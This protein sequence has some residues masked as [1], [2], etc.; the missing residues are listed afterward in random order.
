LDSENRGIARAHISDGIGRIVVFW[1][2]GMSKR[3]QWKATC[4]HTNPTKNG[5]SS[6]STNWMGAAMMSERIWATRHSLMMTRSCSMAPVT[7]QQALYGLDMV[8]IVFTLSSISSHQSWIVQ[9]GFYRYCGTKVW[10][11]NESHASQSIYSVSL[12]NRPGDFFISSSGF[13]EL[14]NDHFSLSPIV[15]I[16]IGDS[17]PS[18]LQDF[19]NHFTTTVT[20][21]INWFSSRPIHGGKL[22]DAMWSSVSQKVYL[23]QAKPIA[24][25][26]PIQVWGRRASQFWHME[27]VLLLVIESP[28]RLWWREWV[29]YYRHNH[30]SSQHF[31]RETSPKQILVKGWERWKILLV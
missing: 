27:H 17:H 23:F 3:I 10:I 31:E 9:C 25:T 24:R 14:I 1:R 18:G 30:Q 13:R 19:K 29:R 26:V 21:N 8:S 15:W 22:W 5:R 6:S 16:G 20:L 4:H 11:Q 28:S 2:D 7:F 12:T